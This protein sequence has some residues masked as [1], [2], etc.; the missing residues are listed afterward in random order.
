MIT[1]RGTAGILVLLATLF[2][3]DG[4]RAQAPRSAARDQFLRLL[5]SR[6]EQAIAR[7]FARREQGVERQLAQPGRVVPR[8]SQ[9]TLQLARRQQQLA[10]QQRS[11]SRL[12]VNPPPGPL[13][14][15]LT[16]AALALQ[17]QIQQGATQLTR[18]E[19]TVP[20]NPQQAQLI[21]RLEGQIRRQDQAAND[22]FHSIER[23]V[24]TPS[25]PGNPAGRP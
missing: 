15:Q 7:T 25:A 16:R 12:V 6:Q 18:L 23:T 10:V 1:K 3:T 20:R 2:F 19:H 22:R 17:R 5:L 24:A 11:L 8:K 21:A 9:Q 14:R 13:Q 4:A